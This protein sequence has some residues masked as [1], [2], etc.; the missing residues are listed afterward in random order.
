MSWKV[1]KEKSD[2][3]FVSD[4]T[5]L[6]KEAYIGTISPMDLI[7]EPHTK[8]WLYAYEIDE[9][10]FQDVGPPT[11]IKKNPSR[12][13]VILPLLLLMGSILMMGMS[14]HY[15]QRT[16]AKE[17]LRFFTNLQENQ[18][19]ISTSTAQLYAS[20]SP[21]STTSTL[22]K[23][24]VVLLKKKY[25]GKYLISHPALSHPMWID[26]KQLIP[27]YLFANPESKQAWELFF[28]THTQLQVHNLSWSTPPKYRPLT[29][30]FL[31]L[32]NTS[33][34]FVENI[35]LS[36]IL[37]SAETEPKKINIQIIGAIAPANSVSIGTL[38]NPKNQ[39]LQYTT[40]SRYKELLQREELKGWHWSP[41]INLDVQADFSEIL[42]QA[43]F[44]EIQN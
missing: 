2:P 31:Q 30:F 21:S 36:I 8:T 38:W 20:H 23:N 28:N 9:L 18:G 10:L 44:A 7:Q 27:L 42:V 29:A 5:E 35:E 41:S 26:E 32:Q 13:G 39:V 3:F 4:K 14:W 34:R 22:S 6:I 40:E 15:Y 11:H 33:P 17:E 25:K 12:R 19:V 1:L 43:V 16:P 37:Q 24:E